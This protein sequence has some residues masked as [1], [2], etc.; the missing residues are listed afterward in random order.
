M[1]LFPN[2]FDNDPFFRWADAI[3]VHKLTLS[4]Q[5]SCLYYVNLSPTQGDWLS[6]F[7]VWSRSIWRHV[8]CPS[9]TSSSY[10]WKASTEIRTKGESINKLVMAVCCC[11][12]VFGIQCCPVAFRVIFSSFHCCHCK[13]FCW[14]VAVAARWLSFTKLP[15]RHLHVHCN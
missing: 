3:F 1:S 9:P 12:P 14:I 4:L 13:W 6:T 11:L 2:A 15:L 5:S 7:D 8:W 10:R